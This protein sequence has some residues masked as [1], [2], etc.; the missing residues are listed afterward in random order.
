MQQISKLET[1]QAGFRFVCNVLKE[2]GFQVQSVHPTNEGRHC[3]IKTDS[4]NYYVLFKKAF[5]WSFKSQFPEWSEKNPTGFGDSINAEF[6]KF[7]KK[8]D[9]FLLFCYSNWRIY[10]ITTKKVKE[11]NLLRTQDKVNGYQLPDFSKSREYINELT[12][13]FPLKEMVRFY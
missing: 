6:L 2:K 10:L 1:S 4:G 5:F 8:H 3:L 13:S 12:Y 11:L 7:A 9:A